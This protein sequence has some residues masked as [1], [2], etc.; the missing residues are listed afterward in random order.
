MQLIHCEIYQGAIAAAHVEFPARIL[1]GQSERRSDARIISPVV[2]NQLGGTTFLSPVST[3]EEAIASARAQIEHNN[4]SYMEY[5]IS[6]R[7][8]AE[9]AVQ[10]FE[11]CGIPPEMV[12]PLALEQPY[13]PT[14]ASVPI[15]YFCQ[16]AALN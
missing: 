12:P 15:Q 6:D 10:H 4:R 8:T 16:D 7:V 11:A 14:Y 3:V 1:H 5:V 9:N 13:F 2:I